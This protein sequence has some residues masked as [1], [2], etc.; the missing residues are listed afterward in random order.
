VRHAGIAARA[1]NAAR[2]DPPAKTRFSYQ[3]RT[4]TRVWRRKYG[5]VAAAQGS[6][7]GCRTQHGRGS[8]ARHDQTAQ[9]PCC[10]TAVQSSNQHRQRG[11][12]GNANYTN[13]AR[14]SAAN[15]ERGAKRERGATRPAC[16]DTLVFNGCLKFK[17]GL[18]LTNVRRRER[19][20]YE[21][22]K[23]RQRRGRD[24][25]AGSE[26]GVARPACQETLVLNGCS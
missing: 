3:H 20:I 17:P 12:R 11:L 21:N 26:R 2:L 5:D 15:G 9:T 6:T 16:P 1:G 13:K 24:R 18:T 7:T 14:E 22:G 10:S 23:G 19:G 25:V 8:A 4:P